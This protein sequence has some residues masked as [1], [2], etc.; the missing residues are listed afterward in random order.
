M[1]LSAALFVGLTATP[2][3]EAA[4]PKV[5]LKTYANCKEIN[6]IYP[7]GIARASN[8]K[9]KGGAT[10][11]KPVV[12]LKLYDLNTKSDRDKDLIACER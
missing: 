7:G 2:A 1:L 5:T 12:N 4:A 8:V 10:K 6:K 9:N 3:V 11:Y